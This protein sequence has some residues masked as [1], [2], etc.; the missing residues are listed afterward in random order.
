[1][2]LPGAVRTGVQSLALMPT[3][4]AEASSKMQA[5][6]QAGQIIGSTIDKMEQDRTNEEVRQLNLSTM[7]SA[8]KLDASLDRPS[9]GAADI[10][11]GIDIR[12]ND[13]VM[14][15]G[16]E[17]S[18]P[19]TDIPAY[20]VKAQIYKQE[21]DKQLMAGA[22]KITNEKARGEWLEEKQALVNVNTAKL[23]SQAEADQREYNAQKLT[24][25][26]NEAMDLNQFDIAMALTGDIKNPD[27]RVTARKAIKTSKEVNGYDSLILAKDD[28]ESW[29][30]MESDIVTLR[31]SEQKSMLTTDERIGEANKLERALTQGKQDFAI[32][33]KSVIA[34]NAA[35]IK[36]DLDGG[37]VNYTADE[38][39]KQRDDGLLTNSQYIGYTKQ[40][41]ANQVNL[42][43]SQKAKFEIQAG[44]INPKNPDHMKAVDEEFTKLAQGSDPWAAT[45]QVVQKYNVLPPAVN[46][47]FNMANITGGENLTSAAQQYNILNET[48]PVAMMGVKAPRVQQVAAYIDLGMTSGQALESLA[49]NESLSPAQIETRKAMVSGRDNTDESTEALASMY[50][51]AF[52]GWFSTPDTPVFMAAEFGALTEANLAKTGFDIDVARKMAFNTIKG[53]Y[54]PTTINGSDQVLPFMPQEPDELVRK[55]IKKQLGDDVII[56]SDQLTEN[57]VMLGNKVSYMAYKDLGDGNIDILPRYEYDSQAIKDTQA[58]EQETKQKKILDDALKER[59]A[60]EAKKAKIKAHKEEEAR[61]TVIRKAERDKKTGVNL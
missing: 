35:D 23:S 1:M 29:A 33:Q 51:D 13:T 7:Q 19:R 26:I 16:V 31:D 18:Q 25:D 60:I 52:G 3:G 17:T 61:K 24:S 11:E 43:K 22:S 44:Y 6:S 40:L 39:K 46:N 8:A 38:F 59:E 20:E 47:A 58:K 55:Q 36:V 32:A 9:Y 10:P 41:E 28:P 57:Q 5:I 48:N 15:N 42:Q 21:M 53:K 54:K 49:L 12:L 27:L 34:N 37:S 30:Q 50:K 14:V 2:K 4:I 56:Q 45:Q